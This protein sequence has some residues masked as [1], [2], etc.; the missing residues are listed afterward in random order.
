MTQEEC[1][2]L[3]VKSLL[4]VVQTG[5]KNIEITV[6]ESYGKIAVEFTLPRLIVESQN[7]WVAPGTLRDRDDCVGY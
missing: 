6:L 2:K 1:V 5:A 4:E 3:T 7:F